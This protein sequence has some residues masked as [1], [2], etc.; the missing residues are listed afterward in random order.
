MLFFS[1][2]DKDT[3]ADIVELLSKMC[4][5]FPVLSKLQCTGKMLQDMIV[6]HRLLQDTGRQSI[7]DY[8]KV[9]RKLAME[10]TN[11]DAYEIVKEDNDKYHVRLSIHICKEHIYIRT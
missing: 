2:D 1:Q 6:S 10:T 5:E 11:K 9:A 4:E 7:T 8:M 3:L